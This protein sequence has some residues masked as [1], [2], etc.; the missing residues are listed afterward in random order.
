LTYNTSTNQLEQQHDGVDQKKTGLLVYDTITNTLISSG[1]ITTIRNKNVSFKLPAVLKDYTYT[2]Y[3]LVLATNAGIYFWGQENNACWWLNNEDKSKKFPTLL[4]HL[5]Y[6]DEPVFSVAYHPEQDKFYFNSYRGNF[7]LSKNDSLPVAMP[8]P[9]CVL[10]DLKYYDHKLL[11]ITKDQGIL[12]WD[13]KQYKQAYANSP[14]AVFY[15]AEI[16]ENKLWLIADYWSMDILASLVFY[17][18]KNCRLVRQFYTW[19]IL[20]SCSFDGNAFARSCFTIRYFAFTTCKYL[21]LFI[22]YP[23][24]VFHRSRTCG[25]LL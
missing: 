21:S 6:F 12:E 20:S 18:T 16:Y 10:S 14:K 5:L 9:Y 15:K 1:L 22:Y 4:K 7:E 8:E 24:N 2:P 25:I 3:G 11:L 13:G 19:Q 17:R 23:A